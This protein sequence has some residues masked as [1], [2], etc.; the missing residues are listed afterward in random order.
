M[1]RTWVL[2]LSLAWAS[3]AQAAVQLAPIFSDG[4]VLQQ[5]MKVPVWGTA[6]PGD[7]VTVSFCGQSVSA[8]ADAK[9]AWRVDLAPL[10]AGGPWPLTVRG[11][12]AINFAGVYV[13]DVW[14]CAGQSNM[15]YT[16]GRDIWD[17]IKDNV[18]PGL[19]LYKHG[20]WATPVYQGGPWQEASGAA[21]HAFSAVGYYFGK[22]LYDD[23]AAQKRAVPVGIID[24]SVGATN[25]AVWTPDAT[26][27]A[28]GYGGG[29]FFYQREIEPLQPF[30]IKGMLWYQGE[31]NAGDRNYA[32]EL[33]AMV[34][35]WRQAWGQ[36]D[37]PVMIVQLHRYGAIPAPLAPPDPLAGWAVTREQQVR[38]A[39][40]IPNAAMTVIYDLSDGNLHTGNKGPI[41]QRLARRVE[42]MCYQ[43]NRRGLM[44]PIVAQASYNAQQHQVLVRVTDPGP[45]IRA[46]PQPH[47]ELSDLFLFTPG[48]RVL[49]ARGVPF[50]KDAIAID[51]HAV[52]G[53]PDV[54]YAWGDY[55]TGN[56]FTN[57]M[58][59]VS[60]F[61]LQSLHLSPERCQGHEILLVS[62]Q[63]LDP[64]T[65]GD[66]EFYKIDGATVTR[67][68]VTPDGWA[69]R[70]QTDR[71]WQL[72][73]QV[74]M[75]FPRWRCWDKVTPLPALVFTVLPGWYVT[76]QSLHE[77]QVG[78]VHSLDLAGAGVSAAPNDR[79]GKPAFDHQWASQALV[80]PEWTD[81][82]R[83]PAADPALLTGAAGAPWRVVQ[84]P[85][86]GQFNLTSLVHWQKSPVYAALVRYEV[87]AQHEMVVTLRLDTQAVGRVYS[88]GILG[89]SWLPFTPVRVSRVALHQGWNTIILELAGSRKNPYGHSFFQMRMQNAEGGRVEGLSY[90]AAHAGDAM[91]PGK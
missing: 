83:A 28:L 64:K 54:Y 62:N 8:T 12:N 20:S 50:G 69:V 5:G 24:S 18:T 42:A 37:F 16:V 46:E 21:I 87:Y 26:M 51:T 71:A 2:I 39:Q 40:E 31:F 61:R 47:G 34:G 27:K 32:R 79:P 36:G 49:P 13:G 63:R 57:D 29:G 1:W 59:W 84:C 67:A 45:G 86:D 73:Q 85:R 33:S 48:G 10:K 77:C 56:L 17:G 25:I 52:H 70:L 68:E 14:L 22:T 65:A 74:R 75:T 72:G 89:A 44:D 76:D 55:R 53:V 88:N 43:G 4:M 91:V 19:R 90:E 15:E 81:L 58:R 41:G 30:A 80:E 82:L 60:P 78:G 6:A 7:G 9:G 35:A 66:P 11:P 3:A 38:A 23:L